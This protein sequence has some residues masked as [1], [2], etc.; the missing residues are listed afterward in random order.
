[1]NKM[2][3]D[4]S[5]KFTAWSFVAAAIILWGGWM[6]IPTHIGTYFEPDDFASVY[7]SLYL[8][9][10]T[11]RIYMFGMVVTAIALVALA[12]LLTNS[13][14][15]VMVWPGAAVAAAGMIVGAV[16]AA[17]YYHHGV[18]G[19]IETNG[20]SAVEIST[21][22]DA[23]RVDTEYVTCLVR[24]GRNFYGLG[25]V[26]VGSGLIKWK[27]LPI[28]IG[29]AAVVIGSAS[30]AITML[31]TDMSLYMPVFHVNAF[32]LLLVGVAVLRNGLHANVSGQV[33]D[34]QI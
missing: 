11:F 24:F 17:F 16:G 20:K 31:L 9:I 21:F 29:W 8:W 22:I 33:R 1:M 28:W 3:R 10:W 32:W 14:A 4:F 15:R 23:L 25:L 34:L 27:I 19:A 2:V 30:M 7:S 6:M 12:S 18:W 5:T 13:Q 26:V